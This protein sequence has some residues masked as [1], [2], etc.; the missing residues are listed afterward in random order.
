MG[1]KVFGVRAGSVS[2]TTKGKV[3]AYVQYRQPVPQGMERLRFWP[4]DVFDDLIPPR[5]HPGGPP[6][7]PNPSPHV[8]PIRPSGR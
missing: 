7:R 1:F 3:C 6:A 8:D 2:Y 4:V 5:F